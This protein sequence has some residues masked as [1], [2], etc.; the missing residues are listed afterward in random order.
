M[1]MQTKV[2]SQDLGKDPHQIL[3]DLQFHLGLELQ[4]FLPLWS[5][6]EQSQI[7]IKGNCMLKLSTLHWVVSWL[8]VSY[9]PWWLLAPFLLPVVLR[10]ALNTKTEEVLQWLGR[11]MFSS[12]L[13]YATTFI[14]GIVGVD[15]L[16]SLWRR[17]THFT[18]TGNSLV[19]LKNS[20]WRQWRH[21]T[22]WR[23]AQT[24][25]KIAEQ[26]HGW[27]WNVNTC[28]DPTKINVCRWNGLQNPAK[29]AN[30]KL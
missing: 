13:L 29:I 24:R 19:N 11:A 1:Q 16:R 20:F 6:H 9:Q 23:Q 5:H 17:A 26:S 12:I 18:K 27:L 22:R 21:R 30:H 28:K 8:K 15:C 25:S 4:Q 7:L 10:P 3:P 14:S 2:V